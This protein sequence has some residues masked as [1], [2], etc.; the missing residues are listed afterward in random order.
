MPTYVFE[1]SLKLPAGYAQD[2]SVI[3][4]LAESLAMHLL[5]K[6]VGELAVPRL[7]AGLRGRPFEL[8]APRYADRPELGTR[9]IDL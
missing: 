1:L 6:A 5:D 8:V 4:G 3:E 9:P 7:Q 2:G